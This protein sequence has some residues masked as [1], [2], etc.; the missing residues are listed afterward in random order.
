MGHFAYAVRL[1]K[2]H[3]ALLA[4][5]SAQKPSQIL[6][7]L[8]IIN[9]FSLSAF[10]WRSPQWIVTNIVFHL[11]LTIDEAVRMRKA[12]IRWPFLVN[13]L[14]FAAILGALLVR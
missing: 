3:P 7:G 9:G 2:I 4:I 11:I 14:L 13:H 10:A 5:G 12:P 1:L 6:A 8:L